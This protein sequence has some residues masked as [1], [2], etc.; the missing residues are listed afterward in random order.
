MPCPHS[1]GT[2]NVWRQYDTFNWSIETPLA[3]K[4]LGDVHVETGTDNML[5]LA[6]PADN[7]WIKEDGKFVIDWDSKDNRQYD[8]E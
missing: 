2:G 4:L 8:R 1:A 5:A 6:S 7:G 3:E